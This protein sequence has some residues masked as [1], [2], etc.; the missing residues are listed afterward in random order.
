MSKFST[1]R[2]SREQFL[3]WM[4]GDHAA[5]LGKLS[6]SGKHINAADTLTLL[7]EKRSS[8]EVSQPIILVPMTELRDFFAFVGTYVTSYRP[9]SAF[10]R[11]LPAETISALEER[12]NLSEAKVRRIARLVA[13][14]A[15][16]ECYPRSGSRT[17]SGEPQLSTMRATQSA[18][19]GQAVCMG[20]GAEALDW[21]SKE[22]S[23]LQSSRDDA[24]IGMEDFDQVA[25]IWKLVSK[26]VS[27]DNR[28]DGDS[29]KRTSDQII[30]DF[31]RDVLQNGGINR[32]SLISLA[33]SSSLPFNPAEILASSREERIAAFNNFMS[34]IEPSG[35][36]SFFDHFLSGLLLAISGN[37][38]FELLRS[39]RELFKLTVPS[40]LW[41][42]ICAAMFEDSNVFT[43][44]NSSG[45]RLFRDLQRTHSP[46]D[47]PD[48]DLNSYEYRI[49]RREP[50]SLGLIS[51]RS[52]DGFEVELLANVT[53]FLPTAERPDL[54]SRAA[55]DIH[56]LVG[57][58]QDIRSIV[59]R[60]QRNIPAMEGTRQQDL[61]RPESKPRN[62]S[63]YRS[64]K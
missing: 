16:A 24:P 61:Y 45:R 38:S 13:G 43:I 6:T 58:L 47:V 3:D 50:D 10:F 2:L 21:L 60:A 63:F 11:V 51:S 36:G 14:A 35:D 22:W 9:Y 18:C 17:T 59:E 39:G 48:A 31:L 56:A 46:F 41:F 34:K 25:S 44:A 8:S 15:L 49:I 29:L 40:T 52:S 1:A 37:G 53:T 27:V 12:Q 19:L 30:L 7:W 55:E 57:S 23:I 28:L 64:Q 5:P 26:A 20:Y 32:K 62:K 33:S 4:A 42:G 54:N